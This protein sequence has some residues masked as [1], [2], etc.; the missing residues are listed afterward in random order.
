MYQVMTMVY[1]EEWTTVS[2]KV[3]CSRGPIYD[4]FHFVKFL[5]SCLVRA[6]VAGITNRGL[7]QFVDVK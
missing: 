1:D 5:D 3:H 2:R 7:S 6:T 4:V